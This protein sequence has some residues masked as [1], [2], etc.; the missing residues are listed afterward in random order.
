MQTADTYV[1]ARIDRATKKRATKAL[2]AMRLS[3][4]D[5]IRLLMVRIAD[6]RRLPFEVRAPNTTTRKAIAELEKGKGK[7]FAGVEDLMADLHADD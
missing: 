3:T 7:K 5:A 2:K 1:R 6:E 4:S